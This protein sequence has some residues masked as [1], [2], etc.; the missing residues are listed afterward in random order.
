MNMSHLVSEASSSTFD[1]QG[2]LSQVDGDQAVFGA[3]LQ[4]FR[5]EWPRRVAEAGDALAVRDDQSA[6]QALHALAGMLAQLGARSCSFVIAVERLVKSGDV[7]RA[8]QAWPEATLELERLDCQ[9]EAL[10]VA[11]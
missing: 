10:L 6:R 4:A 3:V 1:W 7:E 8:R 2:L 9:I 5:Q 11:P